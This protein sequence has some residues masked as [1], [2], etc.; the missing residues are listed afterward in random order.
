MTSAFEDQPPLSKSNQDRDKITMASR[1]QRR[2]PDPPTRRKASVSPDRQSQADSDASSSVFEPLAFYNTTFSTHRVSP[3]YIG[4][5]PLNARRLEPLAH[6]LREILV[7][8]VV[9]GVEVGLGR[10]D[11]DDALMGRSG[12]LEAVE[13]RWARMT[14]VLDLDGT[15]TADQSKKRRRGGDKEADWQDTVAELRERN[16]L[17]IALH[18]EAASFTALLLPSISTDSDTDAASL[19]TATA[20][21]S[22][23]DSASQA[24]PSADPDHFLSMPLLLMRMPAPLKA[25]ISD[26]LATTFDCRVSPLRLGTRSLIQ[27]W[28]SWIESAGLPSRGPLAKD[29]VLN[30]GFYLP[31]PD[32][33]ND[34]LPT[35]PVSDQD[36]ASGNFDN[37]SLGLK[38]IDIIIPATEFRKFVDAAE[39]MVRTTSQSDKHKWGWETDI[40]KRRKLAGRQYEEGWEWMAPKL[41]DLTTPS[42]RD[43]NPQL[44]QPF[45]DAL[46]RYLSHHLGLNLFHPSVRVTKIACGGF[47]M[48]EG[49]LKIFAPADLGEAGND[50]IASGPGQRGAVWRLLG[51]LVD[52]AKIRDFR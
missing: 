44:E 2:S 31:P 14:S 18:Y 4:K 6:R 43:P 37:T 46:G 17:Y 52:K 12:S 36:D 15:G 7:G 45:I 39:S 40:R 42:S 5:Q 28:E 50:T 8:D 33:D 19:P 22:I 41:Q 49:R 10:G 32:Q 1:R 13:M 23:N 20:A 30:L 26:F 24:Q 48:S 9:R 38:A 29:V 34:N 16:A 21:F 3:L 51:D 35:P 11:A 47:V 27:G 25:V